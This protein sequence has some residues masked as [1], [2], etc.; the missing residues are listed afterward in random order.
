L[1][2]KKEGVEKIV[3]FIPISLIHSVAKLFMKLLLL[4]LA[5]MMEKIISK[6]QSAFI[7]GRSIHDNFLYIRGMSRKFHQNRSP[8]FLIKLDISKAFD[9]V[10]WDYLLTIL[11]QFGF[12]SRWRNWITSMLA[13]SS[14]QVLL[15]GISGQLLYHGR[16]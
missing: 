4:R 12:P 9:S 15:N 16:G 3:D 14:S 6:C 13:T 2:P 10:R 7:K 1:L 11:T 5:P 8:I